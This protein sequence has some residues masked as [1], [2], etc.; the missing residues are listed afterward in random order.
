MRNKW[1]LQIQKTLHQHPGK[2]IN[3]ILQIAKINYEKENK[4]KKNKFL[5]IVNFFLYVK[6]LIYLFFSPIP[7]LYQ[8][9]FFHQ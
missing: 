4:K 3:Q 8:C 2:S 5:T 6:F 7:K 9:L 1:L